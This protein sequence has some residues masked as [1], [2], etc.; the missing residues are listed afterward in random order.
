[1]TVESIKTIAEFSTTELEKAR[2]TKI[3]EKDQERLVVYESVK[4]KLEELSEFHQ[5]MSMV[6]SMLTESDV[7]SN[8]LEVALEIIEKTALIIDDIKFN[9]QNLP[10]VDLTNLV[11]AQSL[12]T[13]QHSTDCGALPID[14]AQLKALEAAGRDNYD[15]VVV[16]DE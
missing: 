7:D 6:T 11:L 1:R 5:G 10:P 16:N 13:I 14:T 8:V 9:W 3:D 2:Q 4:E 12:Q 15:L